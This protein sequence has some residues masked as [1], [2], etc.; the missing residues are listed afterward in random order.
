MVKRPSSTAAAKLPLTPLSLAVLLVLA[1]EPR[2]GYAIIKAL[3][4]ETEGRIVPGA[5]TL[6]AALQR[7]VDDGLITER[8]RA[9]ADGDDQRRR[10]YSLTAFGRD[11]ARAELLRLARLMSTDSARRLLPDIRLTIPEA[12]R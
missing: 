9:L 8:S 12:L 10:Y 6:Y 3:E 5:G 7:M 2:H 1:D 4:A 11:V